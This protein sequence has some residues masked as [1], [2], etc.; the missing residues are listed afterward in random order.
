MSA[1][2]NKK[3]KEWE[4]LLEQV[5]GNEME[6]LYAYIKNGYEYPSHIDDVKES[7]E[8]EFNEDRSAELS[9]LMSV[10]NKII[11]ALNS[12]YELYKR[13]DNEKYIGELKELII[14]FQNSELHIGFDNFIT[15][16]LGNITML[17]K[18]MEANRNDLQTLSTASNFAGTFELVND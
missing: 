18:K 8:Y 13:S 12:K 10:R 4:D 5:D 15:K 11:H 1:C 2:P 3:S 14:D 16:A 6:A 17:E 7:E 9:S